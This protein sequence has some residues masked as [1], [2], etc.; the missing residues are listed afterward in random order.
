MN[1][2]NVT[3]P[4]RSFFRPA[5]LLFLLAGLHL[6]GV[7]HAQSS[8]P[9]CIPGLGGQVFAT[10]K[11]LEVEILFPP[12]HPLY[13]DELLLTLP[14]YQE[15]LATN[16]EVGK[17][18]SLGRPEAGVELLFSMFVQPTGNTFTIGPA[19]RNFDGIPHARVECV[20]AYEAIIGFEDI[21]EGGDDVFPE[22]D[23]SYNDLL[24]SLRSAPYLGDVNVDG[25]V[26]VEDA[27]VT[28]KYIVSRA[29]LPSKAAGLADLNGDSAIDVGDAVSILRTAVGMEALVESGGERGGE[30]YPE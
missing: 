24:F 5:L 25:A 12:S 13:T 3:V 9:Y 18:V 20:D 15:P 2:L 6:G 27:V 8:N 1:V 29:Y 19:P 28:L 11:A 16:H 14:D 4:A 21:Q 17:I 30:E 23:Y 10:G 26:G 22:S 7:S